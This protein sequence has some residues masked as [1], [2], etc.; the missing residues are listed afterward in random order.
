MT[1][2]PTN[3]VNPHH[4]NSQ[5]VRNAKLSIFHDVTLVVVKFALNR[6]NMRKAGQNKHSLSDMASLPALDPDL[7]HKAAVDVFVKFGLSYRFTAA[8][9][10]GAHGET[11][12]R[13][14]FSKPVDAQPEPEIVVWMDLEVV[15]REGSVWTYSIHLEGQQYKRIIKV[16]ERSVDPKIFNERLVDKVFLQ[17]AATRTHQLW[18]A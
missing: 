13:F 10:I 7:I 18:V 16:D 3:T 4:C 14:L 9:M 15:K 2:S 5:S 12:L 8:R 17:K 11:R 1:I 6:Q